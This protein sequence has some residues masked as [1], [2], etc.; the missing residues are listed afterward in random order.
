MF[1]QKYVP[2]KMTLEKALVGRF[3]LPRVRP[4]GKAP[5]RELPP[6]SGDITCMKLFVVIL[7]KRKPCLI[8]GEIVRY[9]IACT[10]LILIKVA[11]P[12]N[13]L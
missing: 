12:F 3:R 5:N 11:A 13:S 6:K 10:V 9:I 4:G 1:G 2:R 7:E 8:A